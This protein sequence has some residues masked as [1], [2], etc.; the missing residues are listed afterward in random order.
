MRRPFEKLFTLA[1][2][3]SAVLCV[4]VCVLMVRSYAVPDDLSV[5]VTSP[6]RLEFTN[7]AV[8]SSRGRT[9]W[10]RSWCASADRAEF[11]RRMG[12]LAFLDETSPAR[13]LRPPR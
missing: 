11:D 13:R 5:W 7:L 4:G 9:D 6:G 1:A 12:A 10:W 3:V 8:A 2:A